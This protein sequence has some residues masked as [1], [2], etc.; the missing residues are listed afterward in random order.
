[1]KYLLSLAFIAT[2]ALNSCVNT[3]GQAQKTLLSAKEFSEKIKQ[4]P[5]VTIVDVRTPEE[6]EAGHLQ[7]ALNIDW[8]GNNF[9][10]QISSFDKNKPL[11]VYCLSGGRSSAAATKMRDDGFKEVYELDGGI[12]KWRA[13]NLPE[14]T[15][16]TVAK[17]GMS[18]QQF[19]DLLH[20]D[21]IILI[22]FY[23]QWCAPCKQMKPYLEE[24]SKDMAATVTLV[25]IDVD[26]NQQLSKE[27]KVDALPTILIYKNKNLI[28]KNVGYIDKEEVEKQLK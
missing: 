25:R 28:W 26:E 19:N 15:E 22:D 16:K 14:T 12:M 17:N 27:L 23:A 1:M 18:M 9:E 11:F 4:L 7:N 21:K 24:I 8:K 13:A 10:K 6:F 5:D 20:T 2:T 3:N